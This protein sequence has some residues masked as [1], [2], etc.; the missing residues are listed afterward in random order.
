MDTGVTNL[1]LHYTVYNKTG[2]YI[3]FIQNLPDYYK[4]QPTV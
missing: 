1:E 4:Q 3:K 2:R